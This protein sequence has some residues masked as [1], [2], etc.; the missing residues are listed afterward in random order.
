[1]AHRQKYLATVQFRVCRDLT[2]R[3]WSLNVEGSSFLL[4]HPTPSETQTYSFQGLALNSQ[5]RAGQ[6]GPLLARDGGRVKG[7]LGGGQG[8]PGGG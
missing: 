5:G 1:M 3:C 6:G 2:I 4:S 7:S 8:R